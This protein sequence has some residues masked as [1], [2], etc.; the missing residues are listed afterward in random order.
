MALDRNFNSGKVYLSRVRLDSGGYDHHGRYWGIGA[1][2]FVAYDN[3]GEEYVRACCR[4]HAA[5]ILNI[6]RDR[7]ARPF[8][9]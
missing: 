9:R 6:P 2:L 1:P 5:R 4:K 3:S 7:L 8:P